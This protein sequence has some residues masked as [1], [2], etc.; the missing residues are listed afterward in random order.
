MLYEQEL[1]IG[2]SDVPR[3]CSLL[4]SGPTVA[5]K[6]TEKTRGQMEPPRVDTKEKRR[7]GKKRKKKKEKKERRGKKVL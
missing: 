4:N 7:V 6:T 5:H 1:R 2:A 3:N